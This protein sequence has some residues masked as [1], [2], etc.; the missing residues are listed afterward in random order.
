MAQSSPSIELLTEAVKET[1]PGKDPKNLSLESLL[2]LVT[3]D[4]LHQLENETRKELKELR[5]RQKKVTFLNKL[6][7]AINTAT[8][9]KGELDM[10]NL[11]D[12]KE[13]LKQAKELGC[14]IDETRFKYS[15]D[16]RER[17]VE[18]IR[19]TIDNYDMDNQ[20]QTQLITR[21]TNE[22]YESYQMARSILK[23]LHDDKLNKAR[24]IAGR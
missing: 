13:M 4:R 12:L 23:P 11:T 2:L 10:T 7:K 22:R 24:S 15:V 6:T 17:L 5:D 3:T 9:T 21:I 18:N 19:L 14:D 16:E 8:S 20:M 1:K